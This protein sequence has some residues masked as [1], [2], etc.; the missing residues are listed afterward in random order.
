MT[1]ATRLEELDRALAEYGTLHLRDAAHRLDVSEMTVRRDVAAEPGRYACLGGYIVR[2]AQ[3]GSPVGYVIQSE[4]DHF[5]KAKR[6]A[7]RKA[8]ARIQAH[9]TVFI[10]CGTT[11][12]VLADLIPVGLPLT[13]VC[14]SLDLARILSQKQQVRLFLLGGWYQASSDS[15]DGEHVLRGLAEIGVN[16]AFISAAGVDAHYGVTC[17]NPH[18]KPIKQEAMKLASQCYLV[19]DS[20]KIGQRRPVRFA[21][22]GAFDEV[23]T[24]KS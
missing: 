21:Q 4:K 17:W 7:C 5:A 13:V 10:D 1:K 22:V 6:Q 23:I 24:E 9:D 2:V 16:K 20:S 11:L 19:V 8:L 15:F 18:E 14:Y 12:A 3:D